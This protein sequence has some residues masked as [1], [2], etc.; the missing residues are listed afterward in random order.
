M[1]DSERKA[2]QHLKERTP[3]EWLLAIRQISD[4]QLRCRVACVIWW[5]Y[6][7]W[8]PYKD[9]WGHLDCYVRSPSCPDVEIDALRAGLIQAGY[10]PTQAQLRLTETIFVERNQHRNSH[11]R[12]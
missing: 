2:R 12:I 1:A 9:R 8:R 5:D 4:K 10:T 7:A 6:F 3:Q 11:A